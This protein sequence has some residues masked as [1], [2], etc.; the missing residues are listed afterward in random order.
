MNFIKHTSLGLALTGVLCACNGGGGG[1]DAAAVAPAL[2]PIEASGV[3]TKTNAPAVAAATYKSTVS[4]QS[5][6]SSSGLSGITGAVVSTDESRFDIVTFVRKYVAKLSDSQSPIM[7]DS[8][9]GVVIPPDTRLCPFGGTMT[10]SGEVADLSNI[11]AGDRLFLEFDSCDSGSAGVMSGKF[12]ML[13]N[14]ITGNPADAVFG[15]DVNLTMEGISLTI[16][17]ETAVTDGDMRIVTPDANA[18]DKAAQL[19]GNTLTTTLGNA[20]STLLNYQID[21]TYDAATAA[22]V[23]AS[24]GALDS[25]EF[26]G[27][28]NFETTVPF[29]SLASDDYASEGTMLI[30]GVNGS[31]LQLIALDSVNVRLEIDANG[32]GAFE[33]TLETTW[34]D[35]IQL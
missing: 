11:S 2:V 18:A 8:V 24:S 29:R 23:T 22:S 27:R 33:D 25:S 4:A 28:V 7:G 16:A 14:S 26:D 3:I 30:T 1:S 12:T 9:V 31:A 19:S 10:L 20:T 5:L 21:A 13:F 6:S 34:A 15:F 17:D 32:D 35:L